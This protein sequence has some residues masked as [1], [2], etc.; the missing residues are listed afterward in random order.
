MSGLRVVMSG[1]WAGPLDLYGKEEAPALH[2]S[3][4]Y[5]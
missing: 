4:S 3:P 5:W 2:M 1:Q